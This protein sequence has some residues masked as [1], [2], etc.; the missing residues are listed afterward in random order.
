VLRGSPGRSAFCNSTPIFCAIRFSAS[1]A[2]YFQPNSVINRR[3]RA[4]SNLPPKSPPPML[5]LPQAPVMT[6]DHS[7]PPSQSK[8]DGPHLRS[9]EPSH[10]EV[11]RHKTPSGLGAL[12]EENED[13][14]RSENRLIEDEFSKF[15]TQAGV[16][17][18]ATL[19]YLTNT[20]FKLTTTCCTIIETPPSSSQSNVI[21]P[22]PRGT[23]LQT[24][25]E[26]VFVPNGH[27]VSNGATSQRRNP[28]SARS[29]SPADSTASAGFSTISDAISFYDAYEQWLLCSESFFIPARST[30]INSRWTGYTRRTT[31]ASYLRNAEWDTSKSIWTLEADYRSATANRSHFASE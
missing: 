4:G 22:R 24:R 30:T 17:T 31:S 29:A 18:F 5:S 25:N 3:T 23:S 7:D 21:S 1:N 14:N 26:P 9:G 15:H 2:T 6:E 16:P 27:P 28:P 20:R 19:T 8:R 11:T 12:E 13:V 10:P